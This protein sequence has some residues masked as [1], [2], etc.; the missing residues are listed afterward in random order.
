MPAAPGELLGRRALNRRRRKGLLYGALA[1]LYLLHNDLW[2]W[3]DPRLVAGLPIGLAYH[4]AFCLAAS[5]VLTLL[6]LHAWPEHLAEEPRGARADG[7]AP[8]AEGP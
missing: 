7:D 6:V 3:N 2:L 5:V 1:A 4:L 8:R